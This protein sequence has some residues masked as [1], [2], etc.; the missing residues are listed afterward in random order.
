MSRWH[1]HK[2]TVL[3][4]ADKSFKGS[5]DHPI[6]DL[7]SIINAS[8]SF[9]T[10]SSC[11]GR[12]MLV[13]EK[14]EGP[15]KNNASFVFVSHD[16]VDDSA[17]IE[18][19]ASM[20]PIS[21]GHIFL[22][23]EPVIVHIECVDMRNAVWLLHHMKQEGAFKHTSIVSAANDKFI[24]SIRGVAKLEVPVMYGG[25][26]IGSDEILQEYIYIANQRMRENF[27]AI[28]RLTDLMH[29]GLLDRSTA[30]SVQSSFTPEFMKCRWTL[31]LSPSEHIAWSAPQSLQDPVT[32]LGVPVRV[33]GKFVIHADG[34][35]SGIIPDQGS[36]P[37]LDQGRVYHL[38]TSSV[39]V[40][41]ECSQWIL[42]ACEKKN[43]KLG[44]KYIWR[45]IEG[46]D[47][48][49]MQSVGIAEEP[50]PVLQ[51]KSHTYKLE[52]YN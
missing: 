40:V 29:S 50:W 17:L 5:I 10:T 7:V 35:Q 25:N 34:S 33:S 36:C 12:I 4:K 42:W 18:L 15:R 8:E 49:S 45:R 16:Y 27:E 6:V 51:G 32:L 13:H 24:V 19:S 2:A 46:L 28:S 11:S 39:L 22:K 31:V 52:W 30:A 14:G 41:S 3:E 9:F 26:R 37:T 43:K 21:S 1:K 47:N 20:A 23:L 44:L 48:E 38:T